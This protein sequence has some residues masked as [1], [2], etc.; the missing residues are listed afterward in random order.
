MQLYSLHRDV[1]TSMIFV[2]LYWQPRGITTTEF[3]VALV[4]VQWR[5]SILI[6]NVMISSLAEVFFI[7]LM[8]S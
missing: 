4:T 7:N 1:K 2:D 3:I 8:P 6:N 5:E